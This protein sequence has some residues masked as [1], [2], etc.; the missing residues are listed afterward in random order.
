MKDNL[1][2]KSLWD[3]RR[4]LVLAAIK[5]QKLSQPLTVNFSAAFL[6]NIAAQKRSLH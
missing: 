1:R 6:E 5:T 4:Q 3:E 2:L